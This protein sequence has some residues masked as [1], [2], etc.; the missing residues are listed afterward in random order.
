[1]ADRL[2]A[3]NK[4][5]ADS[6]KLLLFASVAGK[7]LAI[8]SLLAMPRSETPQQKSGIVLLRVS[9]SC[10]THLG[11]WWNSS[12]WYRDSVQTEFSCL[13][14]EM[15]HA[16]AAA[17]ACDAW[18]RPMLAPSRDCCLFQRSRVQTHLWTLSTLI[19]ALQST[20]SIISLS[21][22]TTPSG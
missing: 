14:V 6:T 7:P 4:Y 16:A 18:G 12:L 22:R 11:D 10:I 15:R 3:L 8:A 1:M 9:V 19:Y 21:R 20:E 2:V 13:H 5:L 17:A